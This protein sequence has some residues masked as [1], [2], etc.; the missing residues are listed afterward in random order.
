M[1]L[2]DNSLVQS[3]FRTLGLE[4]ALKQSKQPKVFPQPRQGSDDHEKIDATQTGGTPPLHDP[5][6]A[7]KI[8]ITLII[9]SSK[10]E[11]AG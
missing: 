10:R 11:F 5:E 2:Q 9:S 4:S 8:I 6:Q 3:L 1:Q 7:M